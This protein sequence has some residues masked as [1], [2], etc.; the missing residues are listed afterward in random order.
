MTKKAAYD[1]L[2]NKLLIDQGWLPDKT[3]R[4]IP[5]THIKKDLYG[6]ID[7]IAIK[8]TAIIAVQVTSWDNMGE[9]KKKI[10]ESENLQRVLVTKMN[11]L[12]LGWRKKPGTRF[13]E[14]KVY[15]ILGKDN[16]LIHHK[17][18]IFEELVLSR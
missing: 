7:L 6:F 4:V 3:E 5:G 1:G 8:G 18:V 14:Y 15:Q 16:Y 11:V 2:T 12:V 9:R 10:F 17:D 13:W